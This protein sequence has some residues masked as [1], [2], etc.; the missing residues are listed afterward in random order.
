[1]AVLIVDETAKSLS[2]V[3]RLPL[4][5]GTGATPFHQ[6]RITPMTDRQKLIEAFRLFAETTDGTFRAAFI[7]AIACEQ[8]GYYDNY[9]DSTCADNPAEHKRGWEFIDAL[10]PGGSPA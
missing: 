4:V 2:F 3:P 5:R 9:L 7:D 8:C 6:W 1:V 10:C